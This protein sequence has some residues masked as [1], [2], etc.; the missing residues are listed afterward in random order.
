[1]KNNF[2]YYMNKT[3]WEN[4]RRL[5]QRKAT[6]YKKKKKKITFHNYFEPTR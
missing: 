6:V 3:E 2:L 1:M 4:D 5:N